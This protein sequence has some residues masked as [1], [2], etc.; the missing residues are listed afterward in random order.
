MK[1]DP[2]IEEV[3]KARHRISERYGHDTK[4][5]VQHYIAMEKKYKNRMANKAMDLSSEEPSPRHK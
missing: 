4:A 5:L 3:R 1:T 2:A